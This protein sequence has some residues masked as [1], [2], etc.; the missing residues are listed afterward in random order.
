MARRRSARGMVV[1]KLRS[2]QTILVLLFLLPVLAACSSPGQDTEEALSRIDLTL[3]QGAVSTPP[4]S[5]PTQVG[6]STPDSVSTIP[7]NPNPI[8]RL[9]PGEYLTYTTIDGDGDGGV[10]LTVNLIDQDADLQL[11]IAQL[12]LGSTITFSQ[13]RM[14]LA[15]AAPKSNVLSGTDLHI[16]DIQTEADLLV[17]SG[18]NCSWPSYSPRGEQIALVCEGQQQGLF[19]LDL[20]EGSLQP[21]LDA[22]QVGGD[23]LIWPAWS[24]MG[25][26]I[27][28][29]R[30]KEGP[31]SDPV[32]GIYL[33]TTSCS[34]GDTSCSSE[35]EGPVSTC[36]GRTVWAPTGD[37]LACADGSS[38]RVIDLED[39]LEKS[40]SAPDLIE[41][42]AWAPSGHT[43]A[44][45]ISNADQ[46]RYTEVF[47]LDMDFAGLSRLTTGGGSK[48]VL[49]W[50]TIHD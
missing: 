34:V 46:G 12:P 13:A 42:L 38:L 27:A 2:A 18:S 9:E 26:R 19:I 28:F 48:N 11:P 43:L 3:T 4:S 50:V 39:R 15:Y 16:R 20:N 10:W 41:S 30:V 33:A 45:S 31:R 24:P 8:R 1:A 7:A 36:T 32:S 44:L 5:Y 6:T 40:I 17:P 22:D 23:L 35:I 14:Q 49:S 37:L 29:V 25:D 21:I 47:L